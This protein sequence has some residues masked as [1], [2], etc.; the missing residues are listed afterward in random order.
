M[1]G[2][3]EATLE[4]DLYLTK[5]SLKATGGQTCKKKKKNM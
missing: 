5:P 4:V 2:F 3:V 1:K